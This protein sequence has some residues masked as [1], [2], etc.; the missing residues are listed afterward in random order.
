MKAS[1][2]AQELSLYLKGIRKITNQ[3]KAGKWKTKVNIN[4]NKKQKVK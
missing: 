1:W 4:R 2:L 3:K